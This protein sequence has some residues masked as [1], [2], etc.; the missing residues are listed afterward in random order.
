MR[1]VK[2][3]WRTI[4]LLLLFLV[5][6]QVLPIVGARQGTGRPANTSHTMDDDR[7]SNGHRGKRDNQ[8][9]LPIDAE[10]VGNCGL[11]P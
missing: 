1:K 6:S 9:R 11:L 5:I 7:N 3:F 10:R 2:V 4:A 8:P